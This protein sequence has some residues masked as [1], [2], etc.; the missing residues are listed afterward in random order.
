MCNWSKYQIKFRSKINSD[1]E[2]VGKKHTVTF[3]SMDFSYTCK[4]IPSFKKNWIIFLSLLL[5]VFFVINF[6]SFFHVRCLYQLTSFSLSSVSSFQM[7]L[8]FLI[9]KQKVSVHILQLHFVT[10]GQYPN[11]QSFY[12]AS[13]VASM[14]LQYLHVDNKIT[15][16]S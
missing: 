4:W 2:K 6:S 8:V 1:I 14:S 7:D 3:H 10:V 9:N 15:V 16:I 13:T 5:P 12:N 11:Q